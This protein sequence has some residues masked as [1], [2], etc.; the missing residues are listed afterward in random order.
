MGQGS[1]SAQSLGSPCSPGQSRHRS[2]S[3]TQSHPDSLSHPCS[4]HPPSGFG[5]TLTAQGLTRSTPAARLRRASVDRR[6]RVGAIPSTLPPGRGAQPE[7][8]SAAPADV[9]SIRRSNA[10][11]QPI[12]TRRAFHRPT[13]RQSE[14]PHPSPPDQRAIR[15]GPV[16][17]VPQHTVG[18]MQSGP[19]CAGVAVS[20]G[21][22]H[23]YMT[24]TVCCWPLASPSP[25]R[26]R[27][28]PHL[29]DRG[30]SAPRLPRA[31]HPGA[32]PPQTSQGNAPHR[33]GRRLAAS[34]RLVLPSV[35]YRS[36]LALRAR[37]P[38]VAVPHCGRA[39]RK[40]A[41]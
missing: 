29:S 21:V 39:S 11:R 31:P 28:A 35:V 13:Q 6:G 25:P 5:E 26:Q 32:H 36:A 24:D 4:S 34:V 12:K 15:P 20:S 19:R 30:G 14:A 16:G 33:R 40:K 8:A 2:P 9:S 18:V 23:V 10:D 27:Q 1:Q 7:R 17:A 41:A 38:F 37:A 22:A 3:S